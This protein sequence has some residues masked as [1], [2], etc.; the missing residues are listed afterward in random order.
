MTCDSHLA[1]ANE[2]FC[3]SNVIQLNA[4]NW[5]ICALSLTGYTYA[6]AIDK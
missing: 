2:A 1:F 6:T 4:I 3:S 5:D